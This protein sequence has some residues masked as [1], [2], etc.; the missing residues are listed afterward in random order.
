MGKSLLE[1]FASARQVWDEAE[2]VRSPYFRRTPSAADHDAQAL[3]G[4]EKWRKDL[5]L[6]AIPELQDLKLLEWDSWIK[7]RDPSE[8]R[9]LVFGGRHD[10]LTR[11]SNA[12]PAILITSL[13]FLRCLEVRALAP[14]LSCKAADSAAQ[15]EFETPLSKTVDYISGHSS[16]EFSAAVAAGALPFAEAVRLTVSPTGPTRNDAN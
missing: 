7:E 4:F 8:L 15:N 12:Q 3:N 16:G 10:L 9:K 13:A 6:D 11:S 2:E 1:K 5:D 14:S